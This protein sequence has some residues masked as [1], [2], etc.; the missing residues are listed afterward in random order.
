MSWIFTIVFSGILFSSSP[1][2]AIDQVVP[3][4][5]EFEVTQVQQADE[6]ERFEQTY[7]LSAG[8]RLGVSN[9]NGSITVEAWD[10]NEV[11]V[12]AIKTADTK[13]RLKE[14]EIRVNAKPDS[15]MIET[16]YDRWKQDNNGERWKNGSRLKVDYQLKVPRGAV[17]DEVETVN[18]DVAVSNFTN[19]V[20]ISAVN[21]KVVAS[22]LRGTS[23]LST[24]N[25]EVTADF[26]SLDAG[27]KISLS[28]VN[29]KVNLTLP[30]D[31]SATVKAD[32]LNGNIENDFGLP[33]RKGKY[34]GRDLYG[35][36]G[37]G[38][39]RIKLDSVN[40]TLKVAR[41]N[42]GRS[43]APVTDLLPKKANGDE[44]WDK[45][46]DGQAFKS[47]K[48]NKEVAK[49][50]KDSQKKASAALAD[51]QKD[52]ERVRPVVERAM[53]ESARVSAE[54]VKRTVIA[55][56][57]AKIQRAITDTLSQQSANLAKIA[58]AMYFPSMPKAERKSNSFP[59]K[60]VPKVTVETRGCSI[61]VTGWDQPE[62][63]YVLTR[64]SSSS[65]RPALNVRESHDDSNVTIGVEATDDSDRVRIEVFVPRKSNLKIK[66][67][68]EIRLEGV[69]GEID[70]SGKEESINVRDAEGKLSVETTSGRVR[71]VG[72]RGEIQ[73]QT[74]EG[75][76][77]LEGDFEGLNAKAETGQIILTMP[78]DGSA[79][80][81][82]TSPG[83][84]IEDLDLP[85][86]R[87][88]EGRREYRLGKGGPKFK[89]ATDGDV[90]IRSS[91]TI[92]TSF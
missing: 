10:R 85:L 63:K 36:L 51:V 6:T 24:V 84:D 9:V 2:T 53:A 4:Q 79:S 82:C 25:G 47:A 59:V 22:K 54:A 20:K 74:T 29:G 77:S 83:I 26:G 91:K 33:V 71:V 65:D 39:A 12:V 90:L 49:A 34:I 86:I 45:D 44:D 87:D 72:F 48:A 58:D 70:L 8:G 56:D 88:N 43:P 21:G 73:T 62:V 40:G 89:I 5:N 31:A 69:S 1:G 16:N 3:S 32:S 23:N 52:M 81:N 38:D 42:D 37:N 76:I 50:I 41:Q 7:P 18:G 13:E 19:V 27:S 92:T 68:S 55:V 11:Q 30:S 60:G 46:E 64:S 75:M 15:I 66:T 17:L 80:I 28:T 57:S 35:K 67:D 14:V 78:A 61:K